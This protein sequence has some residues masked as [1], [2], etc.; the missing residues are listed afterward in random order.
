MN[1]RTVIARA[2]LSEPPRAAKP[3][4]APRP[5]VTL[6]LPAYNEA[7]ML[8]RNLTRL[9]EYMRSLEGEYRWEIILVNDGSADDTGVLAETFARSASNIHVIHH[10]TNRGLGQALQTAIRHSRG[11]YIIVLDLDLSY[12][13][14]HVGPLLARLR[15]TGAEVVIAS[16]YMNGGRVSNVPWPRRMLSIWAN[17]F[18][19][20]AA[21]GSLSTLTGMVRAYDGRFL[22]TLNITSS[23]MEVNPEIIHKAMILKGHIEEVPA[24]LDWRAQLAV[25]TTRKSSLKVVRQIVSVLLA[26]YLFRPVM[27]FILPGLAILCV[28]LYANAWLLVHFVQQYQRFPELTW[29]FSRASAAVASA[30]Q[31]APHTFFVG[32]M[33]LTLAIQLLSLGILAL[34]NQRYFEEVFHLGT[35]IYGRRWRETNEAAHTSGDLSG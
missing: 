19:S 29:V 20:V 2:R 26:G 4:T 25:G 21:K 8:E 23:G 11:D 14:D 31:L 5:L 18:L 6:V 7:A 28:A 33:G 15:D 32:L 24:H 10:L 27:F 9:S 16:P 22:R 12:A 13:P 35:R 34:Q 17:R 1:P 30:Y 3:V